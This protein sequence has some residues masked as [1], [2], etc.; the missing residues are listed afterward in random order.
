MSGAAFSFAA[1]AA[2]FFGGW[3]ADGRRFVSMDVFWD[4]FYESGRV[5]AYLLYKKTTEHRD[6]RISPVMQEKKEMGR[7]Y[8]SYQI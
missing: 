2:G 8:G 7:D 5:E 3:K 6:R 4:W 1:G